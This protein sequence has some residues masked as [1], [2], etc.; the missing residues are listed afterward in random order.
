MNL[1][2]SLL[3]AVAAPDSLTRWT[4]TQ[5]I[6]A[7][8]HRWVSTPMKPAS[9]FKQFLLRGNVVD[10][11]IAVVMG[12]PSRPWSPLWWRAWLGSLRGRSADGS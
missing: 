2:P 4:R 1:N 11:A 9:E 10:F 6:P 8:E 3:A 5:R 7:I 12:L